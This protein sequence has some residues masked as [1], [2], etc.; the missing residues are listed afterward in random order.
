MS[1]NNRR[2][3]H[4]T[5]TFLVGT[6]VIGLPIYRTH[7]LY[8]FKDQKNNIQITNVKGLTHH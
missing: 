5:H 8:G 6:N 1:K 2:P 7:F 4:E 3:H